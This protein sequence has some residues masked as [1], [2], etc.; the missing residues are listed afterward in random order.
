MLRLTSC[1]LQSV[2]CTIHLNIPLG[3]CVLIAEP[4][5]NQKILANL[6]VMRAV[7]RPAPI[8]IASIFA[9]AKGSCEHP[10]PSNL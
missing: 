2:R 4:T 6:V 7:E 8:D 3:M 10:V 9:A 1:L 5:H